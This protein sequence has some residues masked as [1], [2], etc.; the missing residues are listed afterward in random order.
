MF[1]PLTQVQDKAADTTVKTE[2]KPDTSRTPVKPVQEALQEESSDC[3]DAGDETYVS[4]TDLDITEL[5]TV[6]FTGSQQH[7]EPK[8]QRSDP[9]QDQAGVINAGLEAEQKQEHRQMPADAVE[10]DDALRLVR[11]IFFS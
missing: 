2:E 10:E 6:Q 7:Q 3:S 9:V 1:D 11:E 5:E 4:E 8:G